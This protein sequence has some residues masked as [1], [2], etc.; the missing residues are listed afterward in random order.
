M[1]FKVKRCVALFGVASALS[2]LTACTVGP[3]HP[4]GDYI[5]SPT[6]TPSSDMVGTW[7][8]SYSSS[9]GDAIYNLIITPS[10]Q[11]MV[12][13]DFYGN[14]TGG[15]SGKIT[16]Y[17]G[18]LS[19]I[20]TSGYVSEVSLVGNSLTIKDYLTFTKGDK[21]TPNCYALFKD[22]GMIQ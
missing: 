14:A 19:T 11:Y 8:S 10:G 21:P 6:V 1:V 4:K 22:R 20:Q 12:C 15:S 9:M 13:A 5:S 7:L 3:I 16:T 18:K 17:N 2:L